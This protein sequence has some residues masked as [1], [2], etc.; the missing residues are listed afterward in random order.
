MIEQRRS[1]RF[2]I[3]L[4]LKLIRNG[5]RSV[6]GVGET[7]NMSSG[8]VLFASDTKIDIGEP[9]EY[10]ISLIHSGSVNLHCLGKVMRLDSGVPG[11]QDPAKPFE[12]A[13]TLERYEFV[14]RN[15]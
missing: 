8:G 12:M 10:V 7:R 14:R 3:K 9:V 11:W 6:S 5:L 15:S 1:K 13:V 2:D 4:P